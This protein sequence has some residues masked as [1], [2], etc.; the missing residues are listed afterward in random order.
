MKPILILQN[1]KLVR[2][3]SI[4]EYMTNNSLSYQLVHTYNNDQYPDLDSIEAIINLGSPH[5]MNS[6][7]ESDYLKSLYK[8]VASAVRIE[9]QYLGICFGAQMFAKILGAKIE[10]NK[11]AE[12]GTYKVNLTESG[13]TDPIFK[14]FPDSFDMFQFHS[15]TFKLPF[16]TELLAEGID[17]KNQA[18]RKGKM[19]GVQF[20]PEVTSVE[21]SAWCDKNIEALEKFGSSK[22]SLVTDYNQ[23]SE[24][25]KKINFQ[26]L[27]NFLSL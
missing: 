20:H 9:K 1:S 18:F 2:P 11:T 16:G 27:E 4:I 23:A 12:Y 14:N 24:E 15:E 10:V 8:F 22:D 7:Q 13:K 17:C 21:V 26:L 6:Y 25:I 3:G 5:S 19:V